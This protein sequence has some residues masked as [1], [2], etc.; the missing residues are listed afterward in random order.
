MNCITTHSPKIKSGKSGALGKIDIFPNMS[1]Y[2]HP[3]PRKILTLPLYEIYVF[4]LTKTWA[5]F[6]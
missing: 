2:V 5:T 3:S 6:R 1:L 4:G